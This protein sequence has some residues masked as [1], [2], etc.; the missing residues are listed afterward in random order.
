MLN[1]KYLQ[2]TKGYSRY[3]TI[4]KLFQVTTLKAVKGYVNIGISAEVV[5][6]NV[7]SPNFTEA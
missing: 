1:T 7:D 3:I 6:E 5:H 2:K 4:L